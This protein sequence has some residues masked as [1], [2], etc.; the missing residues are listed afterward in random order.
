MEENAATE[1]RESI[2]ICPSLVLTSSIR[3]SG[4]VRHFMKKLSAVLG[5]PILRRGKSNL[6][7]IAFFVKRGGFKSFVV[8]YSRKESPSLLRFY[9]LREEGYFIEFGCI[10]LGEV[11]Y[12][13]K[14]GVFVGCRLTRVGVSEMSRRLWNFLYGLFHRDSCRGYRGKICEALIKDNADGVVFE[15]WY[16]K[17]LLLRMMV[18]RVIFRGAE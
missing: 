1:K 16:Q 12:G 6:D 11:V 7:E 9:K 8:V 10:V 17:R 15:F 13:G 3:V 2:V 14:I 4:S 5:A 18:K